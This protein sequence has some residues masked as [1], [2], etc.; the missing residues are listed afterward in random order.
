MSEKHLIEVVECH[1]QSSPFRKIGTA[2]VAETGEAIAFN[3]CALRMEFA[4]IDDPRYCEAILDHI[5]TQP[6]GLVR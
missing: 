2:Y 3:F 5:Y 1:E 6:A 4:Y